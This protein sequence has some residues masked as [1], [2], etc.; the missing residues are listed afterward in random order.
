M[1]FEIRI[2][3]PLEDT[4]WDEGLRSFPDAGIFHT[5]AWARVLCDSYGF[6]PRYLTVTN[7]GQPV[8]HLP[9]MEVSSWLTGRRGVSLPFTDYCEPLF[10]DE[11]SLRALTD[12]ALALGRANRWKYV[13]FRSER[14]FPSD[15]RPSLT[16]WQHVVPLLKD[17][18]TQFAGLK[19]PVRTATRKAIAAG[20]QVEASHSTEAVANFA[21]LNAITRRAHGLPP[22][23]N[24]FFATLHRHIIE[25]E[26]GVVVQALVEG[27][28]AAACVY[29]YRGHRALYKYGASDMAFQKLRVNDLVMWTAIR[30][31]AARGCTCMSMGKTATNNEG[32]RRFKLGWGAEESELRYFKY[33]VPTESFVQDRDAIAGWH[34]VLFRV[35]PDSLSRAAGALLYRHMA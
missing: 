28:P 26:A 27:R 7:A 21:R 18:Q 29:L 33:H 8:A 3:N 1:P 22:Q 13:E 2:L 12:A 15:A 4:G 20:V 24:S 19:G 32:L 10:Q 5:T 11:A 6:R 34:N 9:L 14:C 35:M 25:R 31:L 23:P 16:Y 17:E 30:W